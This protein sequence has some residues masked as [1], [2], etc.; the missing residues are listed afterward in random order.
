MQ[1]LGELGTFLQASNESVV[2]FTSRIRKKGREIVEARKLAN[3]G[4]EDP[5]F[6]VTV[7]D[8]CLTCFKRGL[9]VEIEQRLPPCN[10]IEDAIEHAIRI[11]REV[12]AREELL[13]SAKKEETVPSQPAKSCNICKKNNHSTEAC[14]FKSLTCQICQNQGHSAN[15]CRRLPNEQSSVSCQICKKP[16]HTADRCYN[17]QNSRSINCQLCQKPGHTAEKC[18]FQNKFTTFAANWQRQSDSLQCQICKKIGHTANKCFQLKTEASNSNPNVCR[19]CKRVGHVIE[20]CRT[21]EYY[22]SRNQPGNGPNPPRTDAPRG[23]GLPTRPVTTVTMTAPNED[24]QPT[25]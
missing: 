24:I 7:G 25:Q 17:N 6:R 14:R 20:N 5:V 23:S 11:E 1:L 13:A 9:K 22:N 3:N 18:N 21:R 19:Y 10:T 15:E 4:T 2:N 8:Y 12:N 16:G